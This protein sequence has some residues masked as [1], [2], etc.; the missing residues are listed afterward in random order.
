MKQPERIGPYTLLRRLGHKRSSR[1]WLAMAGADV[2]TVA[3]KI[4]REGDEAGRQRMIHEVSIAAGFDHPN[5]VRLFECGASRGVTWIAMAYVPGPHIKPTLASFRQLLLAL[6]H[7]HAHDVIHAA[8]EPANLLLDA[9]GELRLGDFGSACRAGQDA[10][11]AHGTPQFMAPEQLLGQPL[12]VRADIF[13]AGVV[14]YQVLTASL[15]FDGAAFDLIP[16]IGHRLPPAPSAVS[17]GLGSGFDEVIKRALARDR[18]DR[19]GNAFEFL[20]AFDAACRRT[21]KPVVP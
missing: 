10:G 15:P 9:A 8:I 18:V 21:L 13:S 19:Y 17:P 12:D 11:P 1:V 5:I 14:L 6:V 4:A 20:C 2:Q 16:H 7:V 3:L